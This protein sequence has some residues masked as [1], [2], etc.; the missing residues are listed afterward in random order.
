[1]NHQRAIRNLRQRRKFRVR[2]R[3]VGTAERPRLSV[4]RS[5][6]HIYVQL[7]NDFTGHTIASASTAD[8]SLAKSIGYGGNIE[9]AAK[10]GQLIAERALAAGVKK[11]SF[12]RG[13]F[14]YHGRVAAIAEAARQAGLDLGA[15]RTEAVEA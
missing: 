14:K 4:F 1:M 11:A 8:K 6:K 2:K 13:P 7:I 3:I 9:A 12:D 5:H 15:G 10:V